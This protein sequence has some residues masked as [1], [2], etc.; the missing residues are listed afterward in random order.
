[1]PGGDC[2]SHVIQ[3]LSGTRTG[4]FTAPDHEYPSHLRL[5]VTV[6]DSG[7]M[8]TSVTREIQPIT[9]TLSLASSPAGIPLT[10]GTETGAPPPPFTAITGSKV[11]V[12]AADEAL[13]GEDRYAFVSWSDGGAQ[14]HEAAI[15]QGAATLTATYRF[16]A[17]I[18][19]PDSCSAS[20][21]PTSP[22]G[23][24]MEGRLG[25][26]NDVDWYRFKLSSSA[27]VRIV[28]GD[29]PVGPGSSSIAAAR[30]RSP[31]STVRDRA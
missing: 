20:A 4:S 17:K 22:T 16:V 10:L 12:Q 8:T 28:L 31:V 3:E 9:G 24:W 5:T 18:D 30:P 23:K 14:A 21:A 27:R 11:A 7:G 29:L 25:K 26:A 19:M 13:I 6:T 2:H 15:P 1:M